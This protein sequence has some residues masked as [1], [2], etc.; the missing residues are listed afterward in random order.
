LSCWKPGINV[1]RLLNNVSHRRRGVD[2]VVKTISGGKR[3]SAGSALFS[4]LYSF[5]ILAE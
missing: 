4:L 3:E 5:R 1:A 2:T